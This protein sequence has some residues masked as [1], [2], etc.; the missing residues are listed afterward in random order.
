VGV[1]EHQLSATLVTAK[2]A[3]GSLPMA[4]VNIRCLASSAS[5]RALRGDVRGRRESAAGSDVS[6][7]GSD[8]EFGV[9]ADEVRQVARTTMQREGT[10]AS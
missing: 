4:D 1:H 8:V 7:A 3:S 10:T 5:F 6:G 9:D 2:A